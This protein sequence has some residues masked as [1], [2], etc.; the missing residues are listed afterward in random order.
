MPGAPPSLLANPASLSFT[1]YFNQSAPAP[2][3]VSIYNQ[4]T[5]VLNWT[6]S[7]SAP[8]IV[9]SATDGSTPASLSVS[10]DT[11]S[12]MP[13]TYTGTITITPSGGVTGAQTVNVTFTSTGLLLSS[14]FNDGSMEG[15]AVSPL[16]H[17]SNWSVVNGALQYNGGGHTQVYAGDS[18]W[19]DYTMDADIMVATA[20]DYPGGIRGRINVATGAGY[21]LWL[22]PAEGLLKLFRNV[23]WNIDSGTTLLGQASASLTAGSFHHIKMTFA[24]SQIQVFFDGNLAI[25][26]TDAT[27]SSGVVALDVSNKIINFDN[28]LVTASQVTSNSLNLSNASLSFSG[29]YLGARWCGQP[30]ARYRG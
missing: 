6:A 19:T 3:T 16:G 21:A 24:G 5:G 4:G 15:W 1:G 29:N 10:I 25:T 26:A 7:A 8:W 17:G 28:V 27:S 11:S 2:Q 14:N 23:A 18:S 20:T 30:S 22:Y 9:L 13:G 12:L